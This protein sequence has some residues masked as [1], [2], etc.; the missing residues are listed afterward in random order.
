MTESKSTLIMRTL[1]PVIMTCVSFLLFLA[2]YW[3]VT[4]RVV[5]PYYFVGLIFLVPTICFGAISYQSAKNKMDFKTSFITTAIAVIVLGLAM[6]IAFAF[7]VFDNAT[8]ITTDPGLYERA[9]DLSGLPPYLLE[10]TF[11]DTIPN[12]ADNISFRYNPAI[13][14]GGETLALKYETNQDSIETLVGE[15]S[16]KAAWIGKATDS[17]AGS[18][19]IFTGTFYILDLADSGLPEDFT[20]YVFYGKPSRPNDWNHGKRSLVA[21]SERSNEALFLADAW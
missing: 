21:I 19:G 9:L 18:Y 17:D 13:L 8:T 20:I 4:Q 1:F 16:R 11:P 3:A 14:Q 7:I 6:L 15:F 10:E 2:A 5:E 12:D